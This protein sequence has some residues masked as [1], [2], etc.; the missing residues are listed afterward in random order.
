MHDDEDPVDPDAGRLPP[1]QRVPVT[2]LPGVPAALLREG[3]YL[4]SPLPSGLVLP[5]STYRLCAEAE[6][7]LGRLDEAAERF[8]RRAALVRATQVRDARSSAGLSGLAIPL[9]EAFVVELLAAQGERP[10]GGTGSTWALEPYLRAYD[11]GLARVRDGT[12]VDADLVGEMSAIMTGGDAHDV[13]R[14][15]P[16][17]LGLDRR[18]AYLLT[19]TGAHLVA[20]LE[21]W[22]TWVGEECRQ[23]RVAK[24]A[25]AHY[26]LEVLQ[27]FPTANGHVARAFSTLE[28]VRSG[29]VRDQVVPLSVW[30]NGAL[31]EYQRQIRA[32]VRTGLVHRWVEFYATAVRDQALHQL[33]LIARLRLLADDHA[34]LLPR[35]GTLPLVAAD[36]VGYPV[37]NHRAVCDRFGVTPRAASGFTRR[38][39]ELG[40]LVPWKTRN[41]GNAFVCWKVL[42]LLARNP[43]DHGRPP[44]PS[45]RPESTPR[46]S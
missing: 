38:L 21:Q 13:L 20:L 5:P 42:R 43:R 34:R 10:P 23:P 22:S 39:V 17:W 7:A 30:L 16:G 8:G 6:H 45:P 27:P 1:G 3:A 24:A 46:G 36:L 18:R 4:P 33:D 15:A 44:S 11:H 41:H 2:G 9:R 31:G 40:V 26:Q 12:P 25:L 35:A 29:L 32:V 14:T 19:A 28:L 37:V